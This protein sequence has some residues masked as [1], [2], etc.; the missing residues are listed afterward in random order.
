MNDSVINDEQSFLEA[1]QKG[2]KKAFTTLV[3]ANSESIYRVALR[4][5]NNPEDAEDILQET[6]I[7]ALRY[8][9]NFEGRSQLS[10]WLYRIAVNESLMMI[11]K[12]KLDTVS[13]DQEYENDEGDF[14]PREIVDWC[15]LPEKELLNSESQ[16]EISRAVEKLSPANRSVFI[17]RD[18]SGLSTRDTADVLDISEAAVKT[19]LLRGRLELREHLSK[20]FSVKVLAA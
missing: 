11:R 5:L 2:D 4:M 8:L 7:K 10:T 14:I 13:I 1:L 3:E 20:Y 18:L 16:I 17:L 6:F 12:R 9:P 15:C 19:R